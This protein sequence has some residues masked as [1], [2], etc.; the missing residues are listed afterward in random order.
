MNDVN[1]NLISFEMAKELMH[2]SLS[3]NKTEKIELNKSEDRILAENI[4]SKIN[5]PEYSNSAVDGFGFINSN[6]K[7]EF[8]VVGESKPGKPFLGKVKN[9]EAIKVFTGAYVIKKITNIDT[10]CMEEDTE[11]KHDKIILRK[12]IKKGSNIR[13]I[14]EDVK[15]NSKVFSLGRKIRSVDLSQLSSLG[16]KKI[17]V[18]K[19][20][21]V[22]IFS[23]GD[24]LC[25]IS[26]KKKKYQ[27]F[28]SNKFSLLSMFRKIGCE[29]NDLGI[30]KDD[31]EET[32]NKISNTVKDYDLIVTSG[33]VSRSKTDVIGKFFQ[34][35]GK[36]LFWRVSIK[37]GRPFAFGKIKN[38]PFIGLP[39][40]PVA[41]T[42]TFLMLV[43]DYVK[44]LSG[45]DDLPIVERILPCDFNLKKRKG[46]T[47]WLRGK[48]I[49]K[50][51]SFFITKFPST[52]SGI[53]SS[54][55]Q[56]DGIIEL[57]KNSCFIKKGTLVKFYRYEDILN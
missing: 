3:K 32:Y 34:N 11:K 2:K 21:K 51:N 29:A 24:E 5:I 38:V 50:K 35:K 36:I 37:P 43:V 19:K 27:I 26:K 13:L 44:K 20:L 56:S 22:G 9:D 46:R 52:G 23:S 47:E 17:K 1:E 42:V 40:N 30:I 15:K 28:D 4:S 10:V 41:A 7:K 55:T 39:G 8:K 49:K 48:I 53:I 14:G 45:L 25:E 33:G 57:D 31:L 18:Y 16:L 54:V 12:K 6:K